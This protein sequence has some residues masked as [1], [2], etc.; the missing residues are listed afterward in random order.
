MNSLIPPAR[1]PTCHP[2][3]TARLRTA[4]K[5][6]APPRTRKAI[7]MAT[8]LSASS[9]RRR[10]A[11]V[12]TA[13][14]SS[15]QQAPKKSAARVIFHQL[16]RPPSSIEPPEQLETQLADPIGVLG[17]GTKGQVAGEVGQRRGIA[18]ELKLHQAAVAPFRRQLWIGE[19][20]SIR[21]GQR[22]EQVATR[23]I[24][25]LQVIEDT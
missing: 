4:S 25:A 8:K 6:P 11:T 5:R 10:I 23:Q 18:A 2:G 19:H 16:M 9:P 12:C 7:M 17:L 22:L 1:P 21:G 15:P 3:L 13:E 14:T 20:D 24:D